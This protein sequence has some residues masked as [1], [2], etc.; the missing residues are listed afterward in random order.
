MPDVTLL[1]LAAVAERLGVSLSLVQRLARAAEVRAEIQAGRR[2]QDD[3]PEGLRRYLDSQ[4][5]R[6]VR[7]G[8]AVRRI[9]TRDLEA[10]LA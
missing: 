3:V 5:P 1:S 9:R 2:A 10:W 4:F 8:R 7:I 6:P